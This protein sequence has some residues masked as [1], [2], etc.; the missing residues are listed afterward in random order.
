MPTEIVKAD[1]TEQ[2]PEALVAHTDGLTPTEF[3]QALADAQEKAQMLRKIIGEKHWAIKI[4]NGEHILIEAWLTMARAYGMTAR[5]VGEPKKLQGYPHAYQATSE[6]VQITPVGPVVVGRATALCGTT[7]DR[8]WSGEETPEHHVISMAQTRANSKA[9]A[10]V[11]RWVAVLAGY[12]GTPYEEMDGVDK[13]NAT[14]AE[15][16]YAKCAMCG[17]SMRVKYRKSD[18]AP[19][20]AC[21]NYP[22]CR[23]TMS[24]KQAQELTEEEELAEEEE[25]PVQGS[26]A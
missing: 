11:L 15:P 24:V 5:A 25:S 12:S 10:S 17:S 22:D 1:I 13:A 4:N 21:T 20:V 7:N 2:E 23:H 18:N 14:D 19:F 6:V 26:L 9:I 3:A 8:R 16:V